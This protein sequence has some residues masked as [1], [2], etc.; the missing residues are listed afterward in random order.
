MAMP[1]RIPLGKSINHPTLN[2]SREEFRQ[3]QLSATKQL[4]DKVVV[5]AVVFRYARTLI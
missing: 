5:G 1:N 2:F 4:Y 3:H